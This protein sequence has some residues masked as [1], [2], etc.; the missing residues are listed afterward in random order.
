M[1]HRKIYKLEKRL[2]RHQEARHQGARHQGARHQGA[3]HQEAR[4]QEMRHQEIRH[5][6]VAAVR[7]AVTAVETIIPRRLHLHRRG[8]VFRYLRLSMIL[9]RGRVMLIFKC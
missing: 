2:A 7:V 3:R 9:I 5:P 6:M 1:E 8:E 4:H